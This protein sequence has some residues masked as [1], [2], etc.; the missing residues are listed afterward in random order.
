[1]SDDVMKIVDTTRM[2][3]MTV[4]K[5]ALELTK[6]QVLAMKRHTKGPQRMK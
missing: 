4:T 6:D 3:L 1:M 2:T 5:Q